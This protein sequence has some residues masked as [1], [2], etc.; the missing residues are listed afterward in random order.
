ILVPKLEAFVKSPEEYAPSKA[1]VFYNPVMELNRDLAILAVQA[2]Q[3][4]VNHDTMVCEPLASSGI[5]GVRF[6]TEVDGIKLV[7]MNDISKRAVQIAKHNVKMNRLEKK[8]LVKNEDAN[9]LLSRHAAPHKRFD[10]VDID[11]FGSPVPYIDSAVRALRDNGLI[12]LTATDMA[13]LCGVYPKACIRKYGGKPL[14]TEYNH[15]LAVRLLAGCLAT[16]TAK[17]E[18]GISI[19][20]CH[21]SNHYIRLYAKVQYNAKKADECLKNIGYAMHCFKCF[22]RKNAE[23]LVPPKLPSTCDQCGTNLSISGPL[24]VGRLFDREFCE[25]MENALRQRKLKQAQRIAKMLVTAKS[26]AEAPLGYYVVDRLC[27]K[28]NLPVPSVRNVIEALRKEDFE[29]YQTIF[30]TKGIKTDAP[31]MKVM[32]VVRKLARRS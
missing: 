13:P 21:S 25:L 2:H 19:L 32:E 18:I 14:R 5:R 8:V 3:K 9:L 10:V 30:N 28:L 12:A 29:A 31:A 20:F 7:V 11:P 1:P 22:H 24:W 17:H 4:T 6:A 23:G 27:D 16:M 26:E 15:E